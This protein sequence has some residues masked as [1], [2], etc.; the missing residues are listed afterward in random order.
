MKGFLKQVLLFSLPIFIGSIL[1]FITG[2][3]PQFAFHY[4]KGDCDEHGKWMYSRI[5]EN[6]K[7]ADIAFIGS[8]KMMH[9]IWEEKLA[10]QVE[11]K[12]GQN[13]YLLNLGYCRLGRNL[14]YRLIKYVIE[15]K[16]PETIIVEVQVN[17]NQFGHPIF[18]YIAQ[19]E[20]LFLPEMWVNRDF[21]KDLFIGLQ[22]RWEYQKTNILYSNEQVYLYDSSN[23][24][25][26]L[27][28]DSVGIDVLTKNYRSKSRERPDLEIAF[29]K[30]YI[31]RMKRL[32]DRTQ[33]KIIFLYLPEFNEVDLPPIQR[34][35]YEK[36]GKV[37]IPPVSLLN[38]P[39]YW[40]DPIHL[41]DKGA[42]RMAEWL[43]DNWGEIME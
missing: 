11:D 19:S 37:L 35:F 17:E 22:T 28:P 15:E 38:H 9:A 25:Y 8:S 41:N 43:S 1:L 10:E 13:P 2:F 26:W 18:P 12:Q 29:S 5:F 21:F 4:I 40:M 3:S 16:K 6:D 31:K 23:Y 33:T 30:N 14:H 42:V 20:D 36:L 24:G 34:E 27:T 32:A 39:D 7:P